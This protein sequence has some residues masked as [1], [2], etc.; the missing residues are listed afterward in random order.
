MSQT[1]DPLGAAGS[2]PTTAP[3]L[4]LVDWAPRPRISVSA[5]RVTRAAVP[6]VDVHNHLGRWLT[7][8]WCAPDVPE[9]LAMMDD[10][11][12]E[13]VVNLDG[14][15][16]EELTANLDRYD[17]AH[18]GRFVTFCQ[19][20]WSLLHRPGGERE[21]REQL[22]ESAAR[23]ARGIKVWKNLGLAVTDHDDE[24]VLPDDPRVVGVLALAGELGLPALVHVAD[25]KAFFDPMDPHNERFDEL[26]GRP[27]WSFA[28]RNRY[29]SFER[30]L[31]AFER[32][33]VATPGTRYI[34]AHV[35]C[36]AEDLDHVERLLRTAPHLV[37]DIAGRLGELGRQPRRFRR[38]VESYPD[39]VL[40]GTDAFPASRAQFEAHFRFLETDDEC[41]DYAPG[42][43][44]PPQG[45]WQIAGAALPAHLLPAL[46]RDN[47]RRVL[48]LTG[49]E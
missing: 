20:D 39:R 18:P 10:A 36:V 11:G 16:G 17:R 47:A 14:L 4:R 28:D 38:L 27:D 19:V 21:I 13:T 5:T 40:F 8:D 12:I 49:D 32:L 23:G 31:G 41:F 29:P 44:V 22:R 45:R 26:A 3:D 1:P 35:G 15:W 37:I 42:E 33:L 6:A 48:G 43:P 34:G 7:R 24:L 30:L 2:T 9:L 25:P 46:Y